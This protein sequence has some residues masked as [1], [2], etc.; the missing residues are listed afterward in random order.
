MEA[1]DCGMPVYDFWIIIVATAMA[2]PKKWTKPNDLYVV[3]CM[4]GN[5]N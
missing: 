5:N 1:R 4:Q 3:L 2:K